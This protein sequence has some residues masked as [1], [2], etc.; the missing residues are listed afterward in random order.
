[1]TEIH[2]VKN[3][4][5]TVLDSTSSTDTEV[6][7]STLRYVDSVPLHSTLTQYNTAHYPQLTLSS[8]L[9]SPIS[10][11]LSPG[12]AESSDLF[13]SFKSLARSKM[14]SSSSSSRYC[15]VR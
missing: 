5:R 1:M 8:T 13:L 4:Y 11:S 9:F 15:A 3:E 2:I 6:Q 14:C 7:Y 12:N 10:E